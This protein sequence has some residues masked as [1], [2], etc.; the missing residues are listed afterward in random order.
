MKINV[1]TSWEGVTLREFQAVTKQLKEAKE[2][3]ETLK[4]R[5]REQF[6]Y[7]VECVLISTLTGV[8]V[9]DIMN[10]TR[11]SHNYIMNQLAFLSEPIEGKV[12]TRTKVNGKRYYFERNARK[13]NGGQWVSLMHFLED[14]DKI[15]DN[16]HNLLAC[17]AYRVKWFK[18]T[19]NGKNHNEVAEDMLDLPITFVKPLTDFFLSDWLNY[20]GR[21]MRFSEYLLRGAKRLMELKQ[22]RS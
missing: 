19:H 21:T 4:G 1:P 15:E 6:N 16:L 9:D 13:I 5:K 3:L 20:V 17:F 2:R 22:K 11:S 12:K 18:K 8:D 14:E 10:L 7:E